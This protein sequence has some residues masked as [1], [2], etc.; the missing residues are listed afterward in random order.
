MAVAVKNM[1]ETA[2]A[3]LVDRMAVASLAGA[4]YVLGTL[5]TVFYLIPSLWQ[6][7]GWENS[8]ALMVRIVIQLAA[9]SGLLVFGTRLLGPKTAPGVRAGIFFAVVGFLLILLLTRW[10]SLWI[11]YGSY[12]LGW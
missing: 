5:G 7:L 4:A 6:S 3:S 9:L 1:P 10:A 11:E 8:A 2:S 12:D